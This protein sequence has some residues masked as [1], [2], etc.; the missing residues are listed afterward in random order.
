MVLAAHPGGSGG[1]EDR[2]LPVSGGKGRQASGTALP[3]LGSAV[4]LFV[5]VSLPSKHLLLF[6]GVV[7]EC[8]GQ[9]QAEPFAPG[10]HGCG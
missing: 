2:L 6:P 5:I 3:R 4:S 8:P 10:E 1:P 7:P 9:V